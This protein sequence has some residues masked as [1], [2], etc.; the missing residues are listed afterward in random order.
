MIRREV[1]LPLPRP[2]VWTFFTDAD[3]LVRWLGMSADIDATPG[4]RFR[5]EIVPGQYC[6]GEYLEL[7]EPERVVFSWGWT[8]PAWNLPP[9]AS[10]VSVTLTEQ[11]DGT[12]VELVHDRLPG[13]LEAL[14][15]D[16]WATF[17]GRL[18]AVAEGGAPEPY[19]TDDPRRPR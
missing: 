12:L 8:D 17:L 9:G 15:D 11:A 13:D 14:H 16:G 4:G 10:R 2:E 6:D 7:I 19:P 3:R 1:Q 18:V 5:F